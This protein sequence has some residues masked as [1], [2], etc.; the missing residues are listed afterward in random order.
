MSTAPRGN[1]E[2]RVVTVDSK[3]AMFGHNETLAIQQPCEF[4]AH[5][6]EPIT[7]TGPTEVYLESLWIGGYKIN[8]T[9]NYHFNTITTDTVQY[10]SIKVDEFQIDSIAGEYNSP[11]ELAANAEAGVKNTPAMHGRFN[12]PNERPTRAAN[13]VARQWD[14]KP[15]TLG[16]LSKTAVFI[17]HVKPQTFTKFTVSILDQDGNNIFAPRSTGAIPINQPPKLARR[18]ILQFLFVEDKNL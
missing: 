9:N 3:S 8:A 14:T 11:A 2:T 10:F 12:I 4:T 7:L 1:Y 16:H 18:I 17:S 15:F 5:M 13:I 6:F